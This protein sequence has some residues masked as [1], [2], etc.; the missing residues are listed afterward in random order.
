MTPRLII[1]TEVFPPQISG[2]SVLLWNLL[3]ATVPVVEYLVLTSVPGVSATGIVTVGKD[4]PEFVYRRDLKVGLSDILRVLSIKFLCRRFLRIAQEFRPDAV[5]SV[6]PS[7]RFALVGHRVSSA[8]GVPHAVY[9]HNLWEEVFRHAIV[10]PGFAS[11]RYRLRLAREWEGV[12]VKACSSRYALT[13]PMARFLSEKHGVP[14][15]HVPHSFPPAP[16]ECTGQNYREKRNTLDLLLPGS[17]YGM[18]VSSLRPLIELIGS[19]DDVRLT[20]TTSQKRAYLSSIGV[21]G[22]SNV[23]VE[24]FPG[25]DLFAS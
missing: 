13:A 5:V 7:D 22:S 10:D 24:H 6:Y 8:L 23:L 4:L 16:Q 1:C 18:H 21:Y 14:F 25:E 2:S 11:D 20:I 19:R 9:F 3:R 12:I 17:V 15:L